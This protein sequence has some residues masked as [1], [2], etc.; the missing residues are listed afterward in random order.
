MDFKLK[1]RDKFLYFFINLKNNNYKKTRS[2]G[3]RRKYQS[4]MT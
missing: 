2:E 3:L 1:L 4:F